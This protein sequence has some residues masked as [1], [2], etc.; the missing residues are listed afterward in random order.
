MS[1]DTGL[2]RGMWCRR[3]LERNDSLTGASF[4]KS[5]RA[6]AEQDGLANGHAGTNGHAGS[7]TDVNGTGAHDVEMGRTAAEV[8]LLT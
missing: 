5:A 3:K 7:D 2:I 1:L 4:R 6:A 8:R